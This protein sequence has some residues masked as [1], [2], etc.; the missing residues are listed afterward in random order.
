MSNFLKKCGK[1]ILCILLVLILI[2][3]AVIGFVWHNEIA[4]VMSFK[5]IRARDDAHKDG[6]VYELTVG[7]G[8]YLEDF[9]EQGGVSSDEELIDFVV[10]HITKGMI[11]VD[12]K[13]PHVGCS[14]F[15]A[16]AENGDY[17]FARNY[18]MRKTNTCIVRTLARK[19]RHATISTADLGM[20]GMNANQ[21][22]EGLI[23]KITCLAAVYV[24]LDG[25]NDAGVSCG[26]YMTHQGPGNKDEAT[27]QQTDRPD[28][29]TTTF[30][31]MVLDYADSLEDAVEIAQNYDMHDSAGSSYHYMVADSTGRSAIFEWIAGTDVTDQDG[32]QRELVI[33]YNDDDENIGEQ[34]GANDFQCV[35]NFII[36][37]N[38]YEKQESMRGLDRYNYLYE[39]LAL[40]NGIVKDSTDAMHYLQSV[41]RRHWN[42]DGGNGITVHSIVCN[43]TQK[44]IIWIPN[45]QYDDPSAWFTFKF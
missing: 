23:K 4:G 33:T 6:A 10:D 20:V 30:I 31:R 2:P 19:G 1:I 13:K 16:T 11:P 21:N 7:G 22:V 24:P 28:M 9:I 43:M 18:D 5:E 15:T 38:Y 27:N 29:T 39:Q 44:T 37:P 32:T 25:M 8:Y 35:T 45:E 36:Q 34:E 40:S 3:T 12:I 26:V 14:S 42:N 17:I 41:G